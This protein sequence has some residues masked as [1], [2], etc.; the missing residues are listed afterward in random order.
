MGYK[1]PDVTKPQTLEKNYLGRMSKL[2]LSLME[3]ML[4]MEPRERL[5]AKEAMWHAY[6]DGCRSNE[7]ERECRE[8]RNS[9]LRRQESTGTGPRQETSRSRSGMRNNVVVIKG[10]AVNNFAQ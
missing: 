8:F 1:F 9:E 5:S 2:A 10:A 4:R 3:G 6:F 7:E